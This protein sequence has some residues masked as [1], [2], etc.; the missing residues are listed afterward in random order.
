MI[1]NEC[2]FIM[3]SSVV[4]IILNLVENF[5]HYSIGR[6]HDKNKM[7]YKLPPKEDILK[8]VIVMIIFALLQ[9]FL[10]YYVN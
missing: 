5:I 9:A 8:I 6:S 10:T 3:S 2:Y 7:E 1:P 4:F